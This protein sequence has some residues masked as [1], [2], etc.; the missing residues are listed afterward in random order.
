M[1]S[2]IVS[3]EYDWWFGRG[4]VA[5]LKACKW[6]AVVAVKVAAY[7]GEEIVCP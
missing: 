5:K 4:E 6:L 1:H 2:Q 7:F 3:P